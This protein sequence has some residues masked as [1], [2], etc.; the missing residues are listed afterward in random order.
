MSACFKKFDR[1]HGFR[2]HSCVKGMDEVVDGFC[3]ILHLIKLDVQ[4]QTPFRRVLYSR[5]LWAVFFYA[6][7]AAAAE[8]E[9]NAASFS[10]MR[11]A[12]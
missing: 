4:G 11:A 9:A 12:R 10:A 1:V 8:E 2:I 3:P 6:I 7:F 5:R